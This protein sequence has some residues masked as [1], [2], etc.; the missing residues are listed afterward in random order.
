MRVDA[1]T[2]CYCG[3]RRSEH[4]TNECIV[5]T[6]VG[7]RRWIP[8]NV[9]YHDDVDDRCGC[10]GFERSNILNELGGP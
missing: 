8:C 5:T 9:I 6:E 1:R 10:T 2:W 3:H 7:E 4:A